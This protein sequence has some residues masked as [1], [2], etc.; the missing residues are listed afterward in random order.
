MARDF[1]QC[2]GPIRSIF[3]SPLG[4]ITSIISGTSGVG[5]SSLQTQP[6]FQ[7]PAN[8]PQSTNCIEPPKCKSPKRPLIHK[9]SG[10]GPRILMLSILPLSGISNFLRYSQPSRTTLFLGETVIL[11]FPLKSRGL[12][13]L[14]SKIFGGPAAD[15]CRLMVMLLTRGLREYFNGA[16]HFF[17]R[18]IGR[19]DCL[20]H[21][22]FQ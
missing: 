13:K 7:F 17:R 4:N 11:L 15:F 10:N 5:F 6:E 16:T 22:T 3:F 20:V 14:M 8:P 2:S 9:C 18:G 1:P 19:V 21:I 12:S